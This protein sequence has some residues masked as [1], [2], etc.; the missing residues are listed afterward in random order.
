MA[1]LKGLVD[2][3]TFDSEKRYLV[4]GTVY[5]TTLLVPHIF[6]YSSTPLKCKYIV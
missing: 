5:P 2:D 6:N 1:Q 4:S 3:G